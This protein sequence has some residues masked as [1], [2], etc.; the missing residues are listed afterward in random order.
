[1][2]SAS[3][4]LL[5]GTAGV[6]NSSSAPL[7]LAGIQCVS[8]LGLDCLE[9]EFVKGLKM[10]SDTARKIKKQANAHNIGLSV[11]APYYVNLSAAE[12]GK[13]LA[14]QERILNSARMAEICGATSAVFHAGYYGNIGAKKT[15]DIIIE[16][17]KEVVSILKKERN[18]VVLRPETM[19]KKSQFGSLEEILFL[20]REVDG[21]QP[22]IDFSHIHA[23][24]GKANSYAEFYRILKKIE[25]KLGETALK[26]LHIHISG[27]EY[28][29]KGELKHLNLQDSDF[30]Y[31]EWIQAL[32]DYGVGGMV[33][34]ES[35]NLEQ[36]AS[37][38]KKL[39]ES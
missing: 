7:T 17:V 18:P 35:P 34:C 15:F 28:S 32:K 23:R 10:G 31:D 37:M 1:M 6:P 16:G 38:L 30:R 36:D 39:Y 26:N 12:R 19:G 27:V 5:F 22:C 33:I 20:C 14:S 4:K 11:H 24:E 21:L 9:I 13:R 25:K 3:R 29:A 2:S 8:Q